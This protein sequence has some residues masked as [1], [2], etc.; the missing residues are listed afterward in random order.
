MTDEENFN[1]LKEE[2]D[3]TLLRLEHYKQKTGEQE[4]KIAD[5]RI[6]ITRSGAYIQQ[7]QSQLKDLTDAAAAQKAAEPEAD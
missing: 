7:L 5:L 1:K 6:E 2:H 4:E 3:T